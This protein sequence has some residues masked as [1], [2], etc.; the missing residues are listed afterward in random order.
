M[1]P[2][3]FV[4]PLAALLAGCGS[5]PDPK[6]PDEVIAASKNLITPEPGLYTTKAELLEFSVPG[7][8][9][10]QADML[11]SRFSGMASENQTFCLTPDQ[12]ERGFEDMV[13]QMGEGRNGMSCDFTRFDADGGDLDAAM[14]CSGPAGLEADM[15]LTGSMTTDS[16][17]MRMEMKQSA[18]MIPGG[19]M[20]MVLQ[21]NSQRT[22]DCPAG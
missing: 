4:L 15:A 3:F 12:A 19:E 1:R 11:R 7:I 16:S 5:D 22:G 20:N 2:Q 14:T 13:R 10:Q 8:S 17:Q 21:M 18:A 6:S 9:P